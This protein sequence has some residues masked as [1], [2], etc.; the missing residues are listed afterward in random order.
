MVMSSPCKRLGFTHCETRNTRG[1]GSRG[2]RTVMGNPR[3]ARSSVDR[4]NS[5]RSSSRR[6]RS[7]RTGAGRSTAR[8]RRVSRHAR[9][10]RA[11]RSSA[12]HALLSDICVLCSCAMCDVESVRLLCVARDDDHLDPEQR[13]SRGAS[14]HR[15]FSGTIFFYWHPL[16]Q[17]ESETL[18][19]GQHETRGKFPRLIAWKS[20]H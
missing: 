1:I 16:F 14:T 9:L 8:P 5:W 7:R 6:R 13:E 3:R 19:R 17:P 2:R 18:G 20:R 15:I 10:R 4:S 11:F 12:S